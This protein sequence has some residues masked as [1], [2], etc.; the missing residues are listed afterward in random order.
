MSFRQKLQAELQNVKFTEQQK[1][2]L[3]TEM[4]QALKRTSNQPLLEQFLAF[5][6]GCTEISIPVL[7]GIVC[8]MVLGFSSVYAHVFIV[9][10]TIAALLLKTAADVCEVYY[11]NQ[12]VVVL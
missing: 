8:L 10:E 6:N 7:A 3:K 5:W 11:I 12:G 4:R 9:D 1:R 2:A